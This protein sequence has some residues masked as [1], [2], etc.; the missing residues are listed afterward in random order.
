MAVLSDKDLENVIKEDEGI[1]ILNMC[2]KNITGVGYDLTIGF[3]R[4]SETGEIPETY[5]EDSNRYILLPGHRYLVISKEFLYLS[6]KYMATLHSR[7]SYALKG[8]IVSST[9]VDPNY[10]GFITGSLF[11]CT[12]GNVYIKKDNAFTTMVIHEL[13]TPTEK[14]LQKN[15][16]NRPKDAQET[17]H[18][19][20]PNIAQIACEAGD[21]YCAKARKEIEYEYEAF[22]KRMYEKM[23]KTRPLQ[24][25]SKEIMQDNRQRARITFLIGN[26]FDINVG[27]DT[28]YTDFYKYY[29]ER[30]DNEL[31]KEI[32]EN[33]SEWSDL[34]IALG[35]CTEK[36]KDKER[37]WECEKNLETSLVYYLEEQ[38]KRITI[39][40]VQ[41]RRKIAYEMYDSL[42]MF[43]KEFPEN[44]QSH[45]KKILPNKNEQIE[46]Y[47]I[48]FNYTDT[49]E[50]CLQT[51]KEQPM[52]EIWFDDIGERILHIHGMAKLN[53]II[54]GVND[55]S[56]IGNKEFRN[57]SIDRQRLIKEETIRHNGNANIEKANAIID[58]SSIICIF[59][60]SIGATDKKWWKRIAKWLQDDNTRRLII[61]AR[62]NE[63]YKI[64][65]YANECEK[66]TKDRFKNNGELADVWKHI[67]NQVY[68]KVNAD[69]F[70]FSQFV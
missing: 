13:C 27:L 32:K 2:S 7:G 19:K 47:F 21:I 61:F 55:E 35:K 48:T 8:I 52:I 45:I 9:V 41:E 17:L 40:N 43:Y 30:H 54:L 1:I 12:S 11:N 50:Q 20:Y 31:T 26:G 10:A 34:E 64:E 33:V 65:K 4:D 60:M 56:Q 66:E 51:V 46:Y 28:R 67:E 63:T 58:S 6:S 3:I 57:N 15:E 62:D 16:Y 38:M 23:Q 29:T 22:K 25:E 49:L 59:G 53:N 68:V 36:F 24:E 5:A 14:G 42:T 44:L 70:N 37:F 18:S 39:T 69:I